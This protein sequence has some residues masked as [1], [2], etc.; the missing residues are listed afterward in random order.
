MHEQTHG[1]DTIVT[2][3]VKT[4]PQGAAVDTVDARNSDVNSELDR[5]THKCSIYSD[6]DPETQLH[7]ATFHVAAHITD[8]WCL[9]VY[10]NTASIYAPFDLPASRGGSGHRTRARDVD[11]N[12]IDNTFRLYGDVIPG[13][14]AAHTTLT[15]AQQT[16][17]RND[18]I[19]W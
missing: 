8:N 14:C 11:S 17:T 1:I 12:S 6:R 19:R 2:R 18:V 4:P 9:D 15:N 5:Q 7:T 13:N 10:G 3:R 16:V